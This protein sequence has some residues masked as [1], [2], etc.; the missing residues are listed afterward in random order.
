[1]NNIKNG[2]KIEFGVNQV[3]LTLKPN[4][5]YKIAVQALTSH[6]DFSDSEISNQIEVITQMNGT[7]AANDDL[8]CGEQNR[9]FTNPNAK[10]SDLDALKEFYIKQNATD[11]EA[12]MPLKIAEITEDYIDLDWSNTVINKNVEQFKIQWHCLN[13]NTHDEDRL[14]N[15]VFNY[16][17][18][19]CQPGYFYCIRVTVIE[20]LGTISNKSKFYIVQTCAPP[21]MPVLKLR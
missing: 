2:G 8:E 10:K 4:R 12:S 9:G 20:A 19:E 6:P 5:V 14:P 13:T 1:M 11:D 17:I 3:V 16:R 7:N 21:D 15:S 18:K